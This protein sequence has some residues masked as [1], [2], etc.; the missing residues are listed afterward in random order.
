MSV[1]WKDILHY[2]T[3]VAAILVGGLAELGA[4]IPGV[5]VSDPKM[6]VMFGVGILAAGLKGGIL[7]GAK[8]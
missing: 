3:A 4:S 2:G 7:S 6:T 1:S 8:Q 5:T